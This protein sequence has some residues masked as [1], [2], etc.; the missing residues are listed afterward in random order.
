MKLQDQFAPDVAMCDSHLVQNASRKLHRQHCE[1]RPLN[2][3]IR[4]QIPL[5]NVMIGK[6]YGFSLEM[7]QCVYLL[8]L[9]S[10]TIFCSYPT[11]PR[12]FHAWKIVPWTLPS[13]I[14]INWPILFR[15]L[16]KSY[17]LLAWRPHSPICVYELSFFSGCILQFI[18]VFSARFLF[19][20]FHFRNI[21][22]TSW[23]GLSWQ[24]P[25][26]FSFLRKDSK[27]LQQRW[28]QFNFWTISQRLADICFIDKEI[29]PIYFKVSDIR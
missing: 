10:S 29:V 5:I 3:C 9:G 12:T 20:V 2:R 25:P 19:L 18:A 28:H 17:G 24:K 21:W 22:L 13:F 1:N 16:I 23:C 15:L 26:E 11:F 27:I 6:I 14:K 4:F 7:N 8:L